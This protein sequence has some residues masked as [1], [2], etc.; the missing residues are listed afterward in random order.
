MISIKEGKWQ[1]QLTI[2]EFKIQLNIT[3]KSILIKVK[4]VTA[5]RLNVPQQSQIINLRKTLIGLKIAHHKM[6]RITVVKLNKIRRSKILKGKNG[7]IEKKL[8]KV[9]QI[10]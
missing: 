5:K 10:C 2:N 7:R 3:V 4:I 8:E 1:P 9:Q 6:W